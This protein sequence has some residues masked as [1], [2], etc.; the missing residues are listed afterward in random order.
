MGMTDMQWKSHLR[1]LLADLRR[2][3]QAS[4]EN[5]VLKEMIERFEKDLEA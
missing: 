4:P 5:E 2:A 3:L 1:A